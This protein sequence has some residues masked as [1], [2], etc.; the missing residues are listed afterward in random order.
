MFFSGGGGLDGNEEED[1][2]ATED[3]DVELSIPLDVNQAHWPKPSLKRAGAV[4]PPE[5]DPQIHPRPAS[6]C[7]LGC[8][9]LTPNQRCNAPEV[10]AG[11]QVWGE[12]FSAECEPWHAS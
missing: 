9:P 10:S 5:T 8:C 12:G 6:L 4:P 2:E 3:R 7:S 1:E 11:A